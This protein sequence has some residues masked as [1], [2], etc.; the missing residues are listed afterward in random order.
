MGEIVNLRRARKTKKRAEDARAADQ[1]RVAFGRTRDERALSEKE[2][3]LVSRR[4][5][6]H[7]LP[8]SDPK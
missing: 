2:Q 4:L 3:A 6:G 5:D 7:L 8:D 1:N